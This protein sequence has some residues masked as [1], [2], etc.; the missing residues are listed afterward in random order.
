MIATKK[1]RRDVPPAGAAP[2]LLPLDDASTYVDRAITALADVP[3]YEC[4]CSFSG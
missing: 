4:G 2:E 3:P 1:L